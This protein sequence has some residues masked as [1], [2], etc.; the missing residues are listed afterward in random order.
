M[1]AFRERGRRPVTHSRAYTARPYLKIK[2]NN[3]SPDSPNLL[4][5]PQQLASVTVFN[6][7]PY[8]RITNVK[9]LQRNPPVPEAWDEIRVECWP[10]TLHTKTK[11][12]KSVVCVHVC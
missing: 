1:P 9:H 8:F 10:Q 3:L 11:K 6:W 2:G 4:G 12:C 7:K 5:I